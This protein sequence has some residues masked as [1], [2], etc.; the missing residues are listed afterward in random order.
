[1]L[2]MADIAIS[3]GSA[4][5][6]HSVKASSVLK[7]IGLTDEEAAKT[8]RISISENLTVQEIDKVI[9]EI[10]KQIKVLTV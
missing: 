6:S 3:A 4:C 5:D 9:S 1:M 2:D 10:D 7:A 8:I